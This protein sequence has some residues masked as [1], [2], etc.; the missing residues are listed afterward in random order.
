VR[1]GGEAGEGEDGDEV[2]FHADVLRLA[3]VA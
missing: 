1:P 3:V 2:L